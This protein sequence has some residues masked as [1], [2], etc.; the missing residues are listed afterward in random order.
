M[1][2]Q[3]DRHQDVYLVLGVVRQVSGHR[4]LDGLARLCQWY[5]QTITVVFVVLHQFMEGLECDAAGDV[6]A[7][8]I[9]Q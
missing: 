9:R 7:Y 3:G 4:T 8:A 5:A 6:V 1:M 2:W